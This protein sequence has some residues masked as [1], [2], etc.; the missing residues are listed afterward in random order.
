M[1]SLSASR[2]SPAS[3]KARIKHIDPLKPPQVA[4]KHSFHDK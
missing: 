4:S 3:A 1:S 2:N